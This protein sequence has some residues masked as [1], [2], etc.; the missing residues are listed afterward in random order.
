MCYEFFGGDTTFHHVEKLC[1]G[2]VHDMVARFYVF[3]E[4]WIAH[5]EMDHLFSMQSSQNANCYDVACAQTYISQYHLVRQLS[6]CACDRR[7]G[8][9]MP[10]SCLRRTEASR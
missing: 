3:P 10:M 2:S 7:T 5:P 1:A 6:A 4:L 8:A 9:S